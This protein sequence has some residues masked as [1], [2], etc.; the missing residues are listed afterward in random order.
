MILHY[1]GKYDGNEA[2]LPSKEHHPNA[3][4][5]KEADDMKKFS[6]IANL[7]S[8][9]VMLLLAIPFLILGMRYIPSNAIWLMIGGVLGGLSLFPHE[10]LHAICYKKDVYLYQ[11]LEHGLM[12][13][14]GT[15]DM[16]KWHFIFMCLCPNIVLGLIPYIVFLICP[17]LVGLG[18]FGIICIGTGF[19][20]WINVYNAMKQMPKNAKTYLC[21]MHSYWYV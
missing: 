4:P 21:G 20:D 8:I 15:E 16:S 12:F 18:L 17:K 10:L 11:D 2:S 7:G 3:V 5:F 1:A 19:G 9:G 13:V 14:V 6:L